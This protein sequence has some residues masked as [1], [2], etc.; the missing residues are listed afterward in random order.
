MSR[1]ELLDDYL[2][3][4]RPQMQN[5]YMLKKIETENFE[6]LC[7]SRLQGNPQIDSYNIFTIDNTE[8][9]YF[10]INAIRYY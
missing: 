6:K 2:N 1:E 8:Y 4:V 3:K 10:K 7:L 5:D 9:V